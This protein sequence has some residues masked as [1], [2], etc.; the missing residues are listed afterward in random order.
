MDISFLLTDDPP[1]QLTLKRK[2]S[3]T[4]LSDKHS[5]KKRSN[6]TPEEDEKLI[7]LK[8]QEMTWGNIA[9][10][11]T[12]RSPVS[13]RMRHQKRLVKQAIWDEKMKNKLARHYMQ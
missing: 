11:L 4:S 5:A 6:W 7:E 3:R 1:P 12:G 9:K 2:A 13:C 10:E 8:N